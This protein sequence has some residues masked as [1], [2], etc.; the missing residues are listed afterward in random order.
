[1]QSADDR[2][3]V[4]EKKVKILVCNISW[5]LELTMFAF[6]LFLEKMLYSNNVFL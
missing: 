6:I 5:A 4:K 2:Q 1:M 3:L